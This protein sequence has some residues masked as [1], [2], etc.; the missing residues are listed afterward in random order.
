MIAH[1]GGVPVE[2]VLPALVGTSTLL[3]VRARM[4][5]RT[6]RRPEPEE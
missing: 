1:V 4:M 3:V 6:R 5:F 2:E